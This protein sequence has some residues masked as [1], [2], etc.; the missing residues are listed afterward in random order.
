VL[1]L[2]PHV[3]TYSTY[4]WNKQT[5]INLKIYWLLTEVLT[6][7]ENREIVMLG[8][9]IET[10]ELCCRDLNDCLLYRIYLYV[11]DNT[12]ILSECSPFREGG[13]INKWL[14]RFNVKFIPFICVFACVEWVAPNSWKEI[15]MMHE[16]LYRRFEK[17]NVLITNKTAQE[18]L[19][20]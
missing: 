8:I 18:K 12:A 10:K 13:V 19:K 11:L 4:I 6:K 17:K 9:S 7:M 14:L 16:F 1:F 20:Y 15:E 5:Q 3:L 2:P